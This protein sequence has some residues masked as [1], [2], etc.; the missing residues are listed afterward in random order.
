MDVLDKAFDR[1]V[2]ENT[3][4]VLANMA[5]AMNTAEAEPEGKAWDT[6]GNEVHSR[7][8]LDMKGTCTL[9]LN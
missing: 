8:Y 9:V 7:I 6:G 3:V 4:N 2:M 1:G 5:E